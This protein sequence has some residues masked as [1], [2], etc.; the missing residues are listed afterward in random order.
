MA[1]GKAA[2]SSPALSS[3][4]LEAADSGQP[5]PRPVSPPAGGVGTSVLGEGGRGMSLHLVV[6]ML[7]AETGTEMETGKHFRR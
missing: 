2:L 1:W 4:W 5:P 7:P 3:S 6:Q